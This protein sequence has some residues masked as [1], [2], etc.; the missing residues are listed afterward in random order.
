MQKT[1]IFS[2]LGKFALRG[3]IFGLSALAVF[4]AGIFTI[5]YVA[6]Q[7]PSGTFGQILNKILSSGDWQNS[8]GTVKN[9]SQL[10]GLDASKYQKISGANQRCP[11]NK[12][13][14]G[15]DNSGNLLCN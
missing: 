10:G 7:N 11:A 1:T 8:D 3:A 9:A 5:S 14:A 12:C 13:V 4:V 6:A 15:F 2:S